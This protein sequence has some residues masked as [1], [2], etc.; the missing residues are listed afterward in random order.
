MSIINGAGLNSFRQQ[1]THGTAYALAEI[2]DNSI[3]WK[4][5]ELTSEI[6]IIM[7]ENEIKGL[8]RLEDIII[9]DNGQGMNEETLAICLNFGGGTNHGNITK[10]A[11]GRYGLGLP[12]SSCSQTKNYHVYSW[13]KKGE[14]R[15][16]F[17]DHDRFDLNDAVVA[18]PVDTLHNGLPADFKTLLPDLTNYESGTIVH[19]KNCDKLDVARAATLINHINLIIGRI[20]RHYIGNGVSINFLVHRK[21]GNTYTAVPDLSGP[22]KIFDP[23]FLKTNTVLPGEFGQ[24]ATNEPWGGTNNSGT[25]KILFEEKRDGKIIAHELEL[26]FSIA[27]SETQRAGG[28]SELGKYYKKA[29]GISLVRANRELKLDHFNFPFPNGQ[30]DPR[31]RWWSVEVKFEPVSDVILNVNANKTDALNFR[32]I[33]SDDYHE[34]ERDGFVDDYIKLRHQLSKE[35]DKAIKGMFETVKLNGA[36]GITVRKSCPDCGEHTL[37]NNKCDACGYKVERCEIH[38]TILLKNSK[39]EV[40]VKTVSLDICVIH[41]TPKTKGI[42]DK[43]KEIDTPIK[44]TEDEEK[45]LIDIIKSNYP[46]VAEDD[47]QLKIILHWFLN[48]QKNHFIIFTDFRTPTIFVNHHEFQSRFRIIEINTR[49]PFYEQYM[50][51]MITEEGDK[52]TPLLLFI[53]SWIHTESEDYTNSKVLERFRGNFGYH[54]SDLMSEWSVN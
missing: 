18:E 17:R 14:V 20:Y 47:S 49:H 37:L 16:T 39:C 36:G 4:R 40:C 35:I 38:P 51:K 10:G 7:I 52:L 44:L 43:C 26:N 30:G 53:S 8:S 41:K 13:Q 15:H 33:S 45:E 27:K 50:E 3:Q 25:Q 2:I 1:F 6:N 28:N 54:L 12:Y 42:C 48:S 46:E 5:P 31:H 23:L 19:W 24:E 29:I 34:M 9:T 22:I 32:Y 11:L 21:N